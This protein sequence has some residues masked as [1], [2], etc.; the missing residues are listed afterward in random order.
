MRLDAHRI[1][2]SA[3]SA[4]AAFSACMMAMM[5]RGVDA[6]RVQRAHDIGE[7]RARLERHELRVSLLDVD[8]RLR[9]HRRLAPARTAPAATRRNCVAMRT[10][11]LPCATAAGPSRTSPPS[12]TVPVRSLMTTRAVA[13]TRDR[14]R[15]E[16]GDQ[17]GK[18]RAILQR[19]LHAT[20]CRRRLTCAASPPELHVDRPRDAPRRD[21]VRVAQRQA[22]RRRRRVTGAAAPPAPARRPARGRPSGDSPATLLPPPP[23][24]KPPIDSGPC[25]S[26][27]TLPSG[28]RSGVGSRV[29][30]CRLRASPIDEAVTSSR[31]PVCAIRTELA[32]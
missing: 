21:E 5:S 30:P 12:T 17:I 13:S 1:T 23:A 28:P 22:Q 19:H 32:R 10:D 18:R 7:R 14:Q 24:P 8:L 9:H 16:P 27:T 26:A 3:R 6:E 15:L 2:S 25:A 11:R 29:P 20:P 31:A 4:P